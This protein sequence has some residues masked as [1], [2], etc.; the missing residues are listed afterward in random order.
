MASR[1]SV[2]CPFAFLN[3]C[4]EYTW[5]TISAPD[6]AQASWGVAM[7]ASRWE[8]LKQLL[9]LAL[10][11]EPGER[12]AFLKEACAEDEP[13]RQE[14][15][16]L[17]AAYQEAGVTIKGSLRIPSVFHS[18]AIQEAVPHQRIGP[19]QVL[20]SVGSGGMATVYLAVR[21]DDEYRK[22]VAIKVIQPG[23]ANQELL[24]RFRNERQTLAALDHPN[25]VRL[26]DGGTTE[27]GMPYLVMDYVEGTPIDAYCDGHKLATDERLRL[28]LAVCSAV[29]YAHQRLVIHRDLKPGTGFKSR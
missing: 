27:D 17:L 22:S 9:D 28:F 18:A 16:S 13:L 15:E 25:I 24:R 3:D 11:K 5:S 29:S 19:Y 21:A 1:G 6:F 2:S 10:E 4:L 8:R 14:V 23:I 26:L 7:D 20:R 12:S